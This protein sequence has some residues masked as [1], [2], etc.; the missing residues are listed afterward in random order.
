MSPRK[1]NKGKKK[2]PPPST[3]AYSERSESEADQEPSRPTRRAP[4]VYSSQQTIE[5]LTITAD[6]DPWN[7][8]HG[9]KGKAWQ[10]IADRLAQS[11]LFT[12]KSLTQQSV[13]EKIAELLASH[14]RPERTVFSETE[15]KLYDGLIDQVEGLVQKAASSNNDKNEKLQARNK[16][17]NLEGELARYNALHAY[18]E[19]KRAQ[20]R[21]NEDSVTNDFAQPSDRPGPSRYVLPDAN[22]NPA[23][24]HSPTPSPDRSSGP[25]TDPLA[26]L[27]S[28][29]GCYLN[30][31]STRTNQA[32][33]TLSDISTSLKQIVSSHT[34]LV[35]EQKEHNRLLRLLLSQEPTTSLIRPCSSSDEVPQPSNQPQ[36]RSGLDLGEVEEHNRDVEPLTVGETEEILGMDRAEF[37]VPGVNE[38]VELSEDGSMSMGCQPTARSKRRKFNSKPVD[39]PRQLRSRKP[40]N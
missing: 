36:P 22:P 16:R 4:F 39:P 2:A 9:S 31:E 12:G 40:K 5:L 11:P 14:G 20:T 35:T 3:P 21:D 19:R 18:G 26:L 30:S 1:S 25:D 27:A 38:P 10:A 6:I 8:P 37:G 15:A 33:D 29:L 23:S 24:I 28:N 13:A 17:L 34:E 32:H 7:Q